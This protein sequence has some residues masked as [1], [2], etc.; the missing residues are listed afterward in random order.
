MSLMRLR[1][2]TLIEDIFSV[3]EDLGMVRRDLGTQAQFNFL[4][5]NLSRRVSIFL[6]KV[7]LLA[8]VRH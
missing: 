2:L 7:K 3:K 6:F 4:T 8:D 1:L 5:C